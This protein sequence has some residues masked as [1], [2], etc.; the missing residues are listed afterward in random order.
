[1]S[2]TYAYFIEA[3]HVITLSHNSIITANCY[4]TSSRRAVAANCSYRRLFERHQRT[5]EVEKRLPKP[6]YFR[7]IIFIQGHQIKTSTEE[8]GLPV[9]D[10]RFDSRVITCVFDRLPQFLKHL[11]IECI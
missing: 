4:H 8:V 1:H 10:H 9:Q 2:D 7:F 5:N 6:T 3:Y 11:L